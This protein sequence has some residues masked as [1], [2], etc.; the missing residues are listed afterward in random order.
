MMLAT[1]ATSARATF[2]DPDAYGQAARAVRAE[3]VV[4]GTGKFRGELT[5]IDFERLWMQRGRD[6]LQRTAWAR[7]DPSRVPIFFLTGTNQPVTS[8]DGLEVAPGEII[9]N[10]LGATYH[11][12]TSGDTQWGSISM[13]PADLA[14]AGRA[15]TGRE[16]SAPPANSRLRPSPALMSRLLGLHADADRLARSAPEILARPEV[17]HALEQK[18]V[19]VM[20]RC[21]ADADPVES[22]S[23]NRRH[24]ATLAHLEDLLVAYSDRALYLPEICTALG[25]AERTLRLCCHEHLGMGVRRQGH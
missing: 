14:A 12:R 20:V 22:S 3:V 1:S 8:Y 4:T 17:A 16:L 7:N 15:V 24:M 23:S 19:H 2:T 6:T 5:R 10:R 18:F 13:T 9:F 25:V 11:T 21:L